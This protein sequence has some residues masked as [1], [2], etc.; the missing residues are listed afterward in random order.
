[1]KDTQIAKYYD[2][3]FDFHIFRKADLIQDKDML[4]IMVIDDDKKDIELLKTL[5]SEEINLKFMFTPLSKSSEAISE[6]VHKRITPDL[7]ILDLVMPNLT[8]NLFLD[9]IKGLDHI[10]SIPTIIYSSM[11]N[12]ANIKNIQFHEQVIAFFAK[13]LNTE[14]FQALLKKESEY[15]IA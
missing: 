11:N 10:K 13:P 12:Y 8:G 14:A 7:I 3:N 9:A 5:M 1:M 15:M 6:L 2:S 4:N